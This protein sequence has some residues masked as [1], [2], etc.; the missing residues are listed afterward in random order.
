MNS[1]HQLTYPAKVALNR[2]QWD[3]EACFGELRDDL[4]M[5]ESTL[6]KALKQLREAGVVDKRDG[7]DDARRSI[8]SV[9]EDASATSSVSAT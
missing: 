1:A 9:V 3:G 2:L 8:Y 6:A 5:P 7:E 4:E